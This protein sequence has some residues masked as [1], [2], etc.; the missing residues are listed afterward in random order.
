MVG[1][2]RLEISKLAGAAAGPGA[3]LAGT[4]SSFW[5]A[6]QL[7]QFNVELL[8]AVFLMTPALF[9][10]AIASLWTMS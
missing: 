9:V 8:I 1:G 7:F 2:A 10:A 4:T 6:T 5:R 3:R